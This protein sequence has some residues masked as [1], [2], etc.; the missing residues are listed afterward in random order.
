M[1][2]LGS[3]ALMPFVLVTEYTISHYMFSAYVELGGGREEG[4][5]KGWL[6]S[7]PP[8]RYRFSIVECGPGAVTNL[9]KL[10]SV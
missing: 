4:E 7:S 9:M 5:L 8:T 1:H 3:P 6:A 2:I 10:F